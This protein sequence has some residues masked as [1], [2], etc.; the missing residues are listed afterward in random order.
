MRRSFKFALRAHPTYSKSAA[1]TVAATLDALVSLKNL[2]SPVTDTAKTGSFLRS[3]FD[4]SSALFAP[5]AAGGK[6][7]IKSTAKALQA[8]D[9]IGQLGSVSHLFPS[10]RDYL[11]RS[12]RSDQFQF[13]IDRS[14]GDHTYWG[15]L[16]GSF[17]KLDF[18]DKKDAFVARYESLAEG[19]GVAAVEVIVWRWGGGG[20]P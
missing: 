20:G 3:L 2:G 1:S 4:E 11:Y 19:N 15:V 17:V 10:I 6:G 16:V 7:D 12:L 5:S 18:L 14:A 9:T 13:P 8:L